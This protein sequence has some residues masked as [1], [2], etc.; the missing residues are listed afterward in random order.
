MLA[1]PHELQSVLLH[2]SLFLFSLSLF[3]L[4]AQHTERFFRLVAQQTQRMF[5]LVALQ[6]Q[7]VL[8]DPHELQSVLLH[9]SL[10]LFVWLFVFCL[11]VQ[12]T[13][14][15]LADPQELQTALFISM[16]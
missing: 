12:H 7:R 11:V 6:T 16:F 14:R 1:D 13:Q 3:C 9:V 4:V 15:V 8:A 10:F 5:F 2:I